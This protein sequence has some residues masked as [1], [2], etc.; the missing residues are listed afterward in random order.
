MRAL[1]KALSALLG[2][3]DAL[4]EV[5]VIESELTKWTAD[6]EALKDGWPA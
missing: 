4:G 1:P 5:V 6:L 3:A 2:E